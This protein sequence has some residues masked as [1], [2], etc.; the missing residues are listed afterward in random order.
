MFASA[1]GVSPYMSGTT[2]MLRVAREATDGI[3][4]AKQILGSAAHIAELAE[5]IQ[6]KREAMEQLVEQSSLYAR[7]VDIAVAGRVLD[8][9][10]QLRLGRLH[11]VFKKIEA[12]VD[13]DVRPKSRVKRALQNIFIQ[14]DRAA[15]LSREL[16][17]EIQLFQVP[18]LLLAPAFRLT[19]GKLLTGLQHGFAIDDVTH[20]IRGDI[21][22]DGQ[23]RALRDCDV[24]KLDTM[25]RH[26]TSEGTIV[27]ASA[28]ID[29]QLMVVRYLESEEN[30]QPGKR[31]TAYP[32][33]LT[34]V[35][36]LN[37]SHRNV[38][39]LYGRQAAPESMF[40]AFRSGGRDLV[41]F[42]KSTRPTAKTEGCV[43]DIRSQPLV[44]AY[45]LLDASWHLKKN[46][47][48]LWTGLSATVDES[49]EPR[50]GLFDD[51][52][53]EQKGRG[54]AANITIYIELFV[55]STAIMLNQATD[56]VEKLG[57]HS[58][59]AN[60]IVTDFLRG[61]GRA[62]PWWW[63]IIRQ[64]RLSIEHWEYEFSAPAT[65]L[66]VAHSAIERGRYYFEETFSTATDHG[67]I[68]FLRCIIMGG[69]DSSTRT[70]G[71]FRKLGNHQ[72]STVRCM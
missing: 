46:H 36:T 20:T 17:R 59:R 5:R 48:L 10:L 57:D 50:I 25:R 29:G 37:A 16:E 11:L 45:K 65:Q 31:K 35:S 63:D 64:E 39:Q 68:S 8:A 19:A 54:D 42:V 6:Q 62:S 58:A 15:T 47:N 40:S 33:L 49:G 21:R 26:K 43:Q 32:E 70:F 23:F 53:D 41:E 27:W 61:C 30:A 67:W 51:I 9:A 60:D 3:Q 13:A 52:V 7:M 22:Y 69:A 18:L 14:P 12:L 66:P 71:H 34:K 44:M 4:L 24:E 2:T 56:V 72:P 55:A 38:V 1:H 28:R